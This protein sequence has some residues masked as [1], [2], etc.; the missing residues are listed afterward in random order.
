MHTMVQ[1][2]P[3]LA[4]LKRCFPLFLIPRFDEMN[5]SFTIESTFNLATKN[6]KLKLIT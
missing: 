5:C 6:Q 3:T 2:H 4:I 1:R